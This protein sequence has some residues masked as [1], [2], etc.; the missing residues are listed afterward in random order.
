MKYLASNKN[1]IRHAKKQM[2]M[3]QNQE[4]INQN[5]RRTSTD[6]GNLDQ[7]IKTVI[8]NCIKYTLKSG[9]KG[10]TCRDMKHVKLETKSTVPEEKIPMS[11]VKFFYIFIHII[12]IIFH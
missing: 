2:Y 7:D 10:L 4:K 5:P 1:V 12:Y 3:M 8:Y 6:V 11:L 9:R